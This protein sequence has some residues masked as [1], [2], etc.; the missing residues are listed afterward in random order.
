VSSS[1]TG[2]SN[3]LVVEEF[4]GSEVISDPLSEDAVFTS[5]L[6]GLSSHGLV[7]RGIELGSEEVGDGVSGEVDLSDSVSHVGEVVIDDVINEFSDVDN[8]GVVS[9]DRGLLVFVVVE[10][11]ESSVVE[12]GQDGDC[13][14][15]VLE[16]SQQ[17]V[18]VVGVHV[19]VDLVSL[20]VSS[21][22]HGG[23]LVIDEKFRE[24]GHVEGTGN[25]LD[26][27]TSDVTSDLESSLE[28]F[29]E[30]VIE[31]SIIS[32]RP[33]IGLGDLVSHSVKR[34]LHVVGL[35]G[36][37]LMGSNVED[38]L[39]LESTVN[40]INSGAETSVSVGV[41]GVV[42]L[43]G[44]VVLLFLGELEESLEVVQF[45]GGVVLWDIND[46]EES[47]FLH[48]LEDEGIDVDISA[49]EILEGD[50][51]NSGKTFSRILSPQFLD[52][53][54]QEGRSTS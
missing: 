33:D 31:G 32:L 50:T 35:G 48:G 13:G 36:F 25:R 5:S 38:I 17:N 21:E 9:G 49:Q 16:L 45:D 8:E 20:E 3:L 1:F 22:T 26:E 41:G 10:H 46:V 18:V 14:V 52:K 11:L 24:L 12:G 19:G 2:G 27:G 44:K 7:D 43:D 53:G 6:S 30:S 28:D 39:E 34:G 47:E 37:G 54:G 29:L 40:I 15:N 51:G 23:E 42:F 4:D